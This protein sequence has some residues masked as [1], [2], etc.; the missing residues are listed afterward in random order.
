MKKKTGRLFSAVLAAA[1]CFSMTA[2]AGAVPSGS[3]SLN[4][5]D[6]AASFYTGGE[7]SEFVKISHP[8]KPAST[9]TTNVTDG[10]LDYLGNGRVGVPGVDPGAEGQGDRGQTYCWAAA[11]YG[12]WMYVTTLYNASMA[13]IGLMDNGLGHDYDPETLKALFDAMYR[14]ELFVQEEDGQNPGSALCKINVKTGEVQ[15]LMSKEKTRTNV[16]FRNALNFNDKLYFCGAVNGIPSI[17]EIDPENNDKITC[18]FQDESMK[19]PG[20]WPEALKKQLSPAIRGMTVYEDKH[21][22]INCVG[23]DENPYIAISQDPS[24][25]F[26]KIAFAWENVEQKIPGELLGYPACHLSDSIY[27]GSIWEIIPFNGDLY[28]GIC[29]GTPDNSPDGGRTMQSFALMRGHCEGDPEDRDAWTW[30]PVIGDKADGAK[31]TFGIDPAR[32]R[33]GACTLMVLD[34]HLYIGEYNDTEIALVKL[35][36]NMDA[37]FMADN[38]EQSV[39]LYR[40]DKDENIE[41]VAGDPTEMFPKSLSGMGSGFDKRENQYIWKMDTFEDKLYV[42]TFDESSL[43]YPAGQISS[44][45]ILHLTPE[46][47]QRQMK[48]LKV[49]IDQLIANSKEDKEE[50]TAAVEALSAAYDSAAVLS[51][52]DEIDSLTDLS[53]AMLQLE[54][55]LV[56]PDS[57]TLEQKLEAKVTFAQQ[58]RKMYDYYYSAQVQALL[59]DFVKD[60]YEQILNNETLQKVE[61]LARCVVYLHDTTRGFDLLVSEDGVNFDC[62]T[63]DGLGDGHNQGLR[64]FAINRDEENPWMCVGTANPFY[65][66]QIWRMEDENMVFPSAFPFIDVNENDWFYDGVRFTWERGLFSGI[67]PNQFGPKIEMTRAMLAQVLYGMEGKPAVSGEASF[68]DV[69]GDA[70]YADAVRWAAA[71]GVMSGYDNGKFGPED[72][73]T[74]EQLAVILYAMADRPEAKQELTFADAGEISDWAV[75]AIRWCVE[76]GILAGVGGNRMAPAATATRAEGAVMLMQLIRTVK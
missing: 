62:I 20:A 56:Q 57:W 58:Y 16:N 14:G 18:V 28:V 33:S 45:D 71:E 46:Q 9:D 67:T 24:K 60:I 8:E 51:A 43:L 10:L 3:G 72:V 49:L 64:A 42:G 4:V 22:V 54:D 23:L 50:E 26:E 39:N 11:T 36:F 1:M 15:V 35:M 55:E 31:Y 12:D 52:E 21:L 53:L 63:R 75:D 37:G 25:G 44:G 27:G 65:G 32:T 30:T 17:Y 7:G 13:T 48:Y 73:V 2:Q 61:S 40:M 70:W 5:A 47:W 29:T 76:N 69:A 66:T 68:P 38:L 41:L 34:D 19:K 59:P 74:R 6:R